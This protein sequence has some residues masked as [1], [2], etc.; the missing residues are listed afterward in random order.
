LID[1]LSIFLKTLGRHPLEAPVRTPLHKTRSKVAFM[2]HTILI[3]LYD[4]STLAK[5]YGIKSETKT[6][7]R[8]EKSMAF[9]FRQM[10]TT[11][12]KITRP[13]LH[14]TTS[15][16]WLQEL[17]SAYLCLLPLLA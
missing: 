10:S 13:R 12:K 7:I 11:T 8:E 1:P 15:P 4:N 16:H 9:I 3:F 17:F 14:A 6:T 5:A 2:Q